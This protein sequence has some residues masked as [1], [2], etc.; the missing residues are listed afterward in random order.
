MAG[1]YQSYFNQKWRRTF[2]AELL[3]TDIKIPPLEIEHFNTASNQSLC[4]NVYWQHFSLFCV[5]S[6]KPILFAIY[7]AL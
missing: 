1:R 7:A 6:I 3:T 2:L 5:A 4:P